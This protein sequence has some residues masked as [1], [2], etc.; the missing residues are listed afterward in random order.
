MTHDKHH[1][2]TTRTEWTGNLGEGTTNYRAYSRDHLISAAGRP[3]LPG[4]SDPAFRGDASRWNPEDLLV[5]SVSSCHMLWYLH[6]CAQAKITV[7]AYHDDATG[8]MEED[9]G[10]GGRFT[11]IV[12]RPVASLAAG[13]D[14]AR[15]TA[16]HEE[17]HQLCFI[18]N[19][20]NFPVVI[21]PTVR[22]VG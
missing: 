18:A 10:G 15:A 12:L 8:V 5:G 19:S 7:L 14:T 2:Y 3:D 11:Q 13:A 20:V 9:E 6:L 22:V 21:E 4:S 1:R 16:L 17:A